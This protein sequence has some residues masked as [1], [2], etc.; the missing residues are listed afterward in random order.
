MYNYGE[1][2][3]EKSA[4]FIRNADLN[5]LN[6]LNITYAQALVQVRAADASLMEVRAGA[7]LSQY[8][9]RAATVNAIA[10]CLA[11]SDAAELHLAFIGK[12]SELQRDAV[13]ALEKRQTEQAELDL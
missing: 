2:L 7:D 5:K 12:Y 4:E 3:H 1:N 9:Q 13:A 10:R 11:D 8:R 6:R